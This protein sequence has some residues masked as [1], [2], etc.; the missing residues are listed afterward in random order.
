MS[1]YPSSE[2]LREAE[3]R[4][5]ELYYIESM[6]DR[7]EL[8]GSDVY[9]PTDGE[10]GNLPTEKE[11]VL[12]WSFDN[13]GYN[14]EYGRD[15]YEHPTENFTYLDPYKIDDF[16][17]MMVCRTSEYNP[18]TQE[19]DVIEANPNDPSHLFEVM[20]RSESNRV[21]GTL[22]LFQEKNVTK[23]SQVSEFFWKEAM[24]GEYEKRG[25]KAHIASS[26]A[27]AD[28]SIVKQDFKLEEAHSYLFAHSN[29]GFHELFHKNFLL[30][31]NHRITQEAIEKNRDFFPSGDA[32]QDQDRKG[33]DW[34]SFQVM[35]K[36]CADDAFKRTERFMSMQRL[37]E[38]VQEDVRNY[39]QKFR[40]TLKP[41]IVKDNFVETFGKEFKAR[42]HETQGE[43]IKRIRTEYRQFADKKFGELKDK[44][45]ETILAQGIA[46]AR[47]MKSVTAEHVKQAQEIFERARKDPVKFRS[48][49]KIVRQVSGDN[50]E[51]T[52]SMLHN[53]DGRSTFQRSYKTLERFGAHLHA[54]QDGR[55]RT[56][57][58]DILE[59]RAFAASSLLRVPPEKLKNEMARAMR[60]EGY[61]AQDAL[62]TRKRMLKSV[63]KLKDDAGELT[64]RERILKTVA[65]SAA[66]AVDKQE[67][68]EQKQQ[69]RQEQQKQQEQQEKKPQSSHDDG[70]YSPDGGSSRKKGRRR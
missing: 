25:L 59:G 54:H 2:E 49:E 22:N 47:G 45:I 23:T 34:K 56:R 52:Q 70:G 3:E 69:D 55:S 63:G 35:A 48:T 14:F 32:L 7:I 15:K 30:E 42:K 41:K 58:E 27:A 13:A 29:K 50:R 9:I 8:G 40:D 38:N 24:Q 19:M 4:I 37:K 33:F 5:E 20:A 18:M 28:I 46:K 10:E 1:D 21:Q 11:N 36:Q 57:K 67:Q 53:L 39:Q 16:E 62:E 61:S 66:K 43:S 68:Q 17:R 6:Q 65:P 51:L 12:P 26:P 44:G 60:E 31:M 64:N